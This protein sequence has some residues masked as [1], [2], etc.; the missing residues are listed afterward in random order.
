M[1]G[2]SIMGSVYEPNLNDYLIFYSTQLTVHAHVSPLLSPQDIV[3]Q[4]HEILH[5]IFST[6]K[7]FAQAYLRIPSVNFTHIYALHSQKLSVLDQCW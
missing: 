2:S 4:T 6:F 3:P 1:C 7:I 5:T